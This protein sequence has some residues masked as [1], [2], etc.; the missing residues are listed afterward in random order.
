MHLYPLFPLYLNCITLFS[1]I[2][3][4]RGCIELRSI[5]V[6]D[7]VESIESMA[8]A[9]SGVIVVT[10]PAGLAALSDAVGTLTAGEEEDA[11]KTLVDRAVTE[12]L[13]RDLRRRQQ[14]QPQRR[15][16]SSADID[17]AMLIPPAPFALELAAYFGLGVDGNSDLS[18]GVFKGCASLAAVLAAAGIVENPGNSF[19]NCPALWRRGGPKLRTAAAVG[20]ARKLQFWHPTTHLLLPVQAQKVVLLVLMI[21][22]TGAVIPAL[23]VELWVAVL[24]HLRPHHLAGL[25]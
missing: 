18:E 9:G 23:P 25:T 2:K 4:F 24:Q 10:L 14:H 6:P 1:P 7:A 22:G 15:H 17:P 20:R 3:A 19:A 11:P 8:F 12:A 5:M 21:G 16:D 13:A